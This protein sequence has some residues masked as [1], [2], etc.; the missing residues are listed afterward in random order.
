MAYE[1]L[2]VLVKS[3]RPAGHQELQ[4]LSAKYSRRQ[5]P[6]VLELAALASDI[7]VDDVVNLGLEPEANPKLSE[8]VRLLKINLD[9]FGN[10][11]AGS[12]EGQI[13]GVKGKYFE[14]LVRDKLNNGERVGHV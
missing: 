14:V 8:A 13:N 3:Y 5:E 9:D 4:K 1:D 6:K 10:A 12:Q 7:S 11:S 2:K